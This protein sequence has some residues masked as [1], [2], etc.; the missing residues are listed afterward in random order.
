MVFTFFLFTVLALYTLQV[1]QAACQGPRRMLPSSTEM[2]SIMA[3]MFATLPV[4]VS[5]PE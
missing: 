5:V 4:V 1:L 2:A 3:A